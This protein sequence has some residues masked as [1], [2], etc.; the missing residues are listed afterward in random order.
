VIKLELE[1][2]FSPGKMG[3]VRIKNRIMRSATFEGM[4]SREGYVT[5][6]L[7]N[8]YTELA[9]GGT[10]VIITGAS[11]VTSRL[12]V[13]SRCMCFKDDSFI[14][15]QKK[16]VKTVHETEEV[17]I[18]AQLAHN[19]RQGSHPKYQA[20]APSPI[21]Y[22]L[23]KQ[24][25]RK[26]ESSE[27]RNLVDQYAAA[28]RR[29]Y[30][31]GYDLV[32]LHAAHGYLLSSFL[33]P[34]TNRRKDEY[35]GSTMGRTKIL[36]EIYD[37]LRD[38]VGKEF[39]ITVKV[40]VDDGVPN[41]LTLEEGKKI[42]ELLVKAGYNAIEPSGGLTELQMKTDDALPSKKVKKE[43]DENY[44]SGAIETLHPAMG[45]AALIQ[46]GGIRNPAT[47][48]TFLKA[49]KCDF[50]ALSRPLIYEPDLP[51]RW[52]R[53]DRAPAKCVSCNSCLIA[54]FTGQPL[55]CVVRKKLA[56]KARK[57]REKEL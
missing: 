56:R 43:E 5:E 52:Q 57:K 16:L 38:E 3:N 33:S 23:T 10:G 39:P 13:G 44:L 27:I 11:A 21:I 35:G 9:R 55:H 28:G 24:V 17:V 19:G 1:T 53:G 36:L 40:Q 47:A 30:E 20:V 41:G 12:T 46:V 2:L 48:E 26:L 34:Y 49:G 32:Q 6:E 18:G 22:P 8:L 15:G 29:V 50:V 31:S 51:N 37:R 54:I 45:K 7:V 4:A 42:T 25:P 14:E